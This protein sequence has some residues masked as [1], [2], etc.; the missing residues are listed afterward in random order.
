[1][2]HSL[3]GSSDFVPRR[4]CGLWTPMLL[5]IHMA[6]DLII[7]ASYVLIA[8]QLFYAY[9]MWSN[10]RIDMSDA[11][12][13]APVLAVVFAMFILMCGTTHLNQ[14]IVFYWPYYRFIGIWSMLTAFISFAAVLTLWRA[15]KIS[16]L[17]EKVLP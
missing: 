6:S 15:I 1:M 13:F 2:L 3:F 7:F 8:L 14:V 10:G 9:G 5:T 4:M 17:S 11:K 12:Y 16:T